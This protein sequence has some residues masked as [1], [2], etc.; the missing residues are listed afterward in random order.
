ML[1]QALARDEITPRCLPGFESIRRFWDA[2]SGKVMAKIHPGEF[3]VTREDEVVSTVLGSCVSACIRDPVAGIG[4]MNHFMLPGGGSDDG[5]GALSSAARFGSFAME[6]LVN[7]VLRE[8][9][10]RERLEVKLFGG[11]QVLR[12]DLDVAQK[13]VEFAIRYAAIEG[14]KVTSSDLG[15]DLPRRVDYFPL[16]G[17][18]RLK[19]LRGARDEGVE[20]RERD[21][22]RS[23]ETGRPAANVELF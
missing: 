22:L 10:R 12:L 14:M 9:G 1:G 5:T 23:L 11:G 7:S 21:Y 15:G 20:R 19:R 17:R 18:V 2:R 13:N 3:Y 16:T 8:G 4:G 6:H